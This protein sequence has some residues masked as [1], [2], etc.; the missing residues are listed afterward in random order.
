MTAILLILQR[1]E[2]ELLHGTRKRNWQEQ[3][4]LSSAR[5]VPASKGSGNAGSNSISTSKSDTVLCAAQG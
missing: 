1:R 4:D 2:V 5:L 3:G